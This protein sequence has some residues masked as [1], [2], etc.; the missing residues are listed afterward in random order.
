MEVLR[1]G[2]QD[3]GTGLRIVAFVSTYLPPQQAVELRED[4]ACQLAKW[5]SEVCR[6]GKSRL[7]QKAGQ[8]AWF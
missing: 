7:S 6:S 5:A 4:T 8:S 2:V 3:A 1:S